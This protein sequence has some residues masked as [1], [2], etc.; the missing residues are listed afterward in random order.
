MSFFADLCTALRIDRLSES[1][2]P[3]NF[4]P[5]PLGHSVERR[6]REM[7]A[8][9]HAELACMDIMRARTLGKSDP[10]YL[11]E[12]NRQRRSFGLRQI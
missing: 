1:V 12:L 11:A 10:D 9:C 5:D 8:S 2:P 3:P 6:V 4:D 7:I